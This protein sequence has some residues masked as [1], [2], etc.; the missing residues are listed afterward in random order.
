[1]TTGSVTPCTLKA[2]G[3]DQVW[4]SIGVSPLAV[5][6]HR[7]FGTVGVVTSNA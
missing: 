1:M 4:P 3:S 7:N 6:L 5:F 2:F